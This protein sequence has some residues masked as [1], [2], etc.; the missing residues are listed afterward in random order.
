MTKVLFIGLVWPEPSSSAAGWRILHIV[1][2]LLQTHEVHFASAASKSSF[3]YDLKTIGVI[4]HQIELNNSS[5]DLFVSQLDPSMVVF[6]R[7]MIE[8]QYGWRIS[9]SVPHAVKILDTED[10]HF[11][12]IARQESVKK[13]IPVNYYN[14]TAKREIASILRCDLS[15]IISEFEMKLLKDRFKVEEDRLFFLPFQEDKL[16]EQQQRNDYNERANFVFIGNFIHE[17]N[18]RTVELL[19]TKIW[20]DL[21][22]KLPVAELHIYGAYASE[23]VNQLHNPKERFFIKGRADDARETLEKYRVLLAPIPF[24]AGA[25]GKFVDAM[26]SGT[27]SIT[28]V[29]GAENMS[30]DN[31]W[32]GYIEDDFVQFIEKAINLYTDRE[33]WQVLQGI[34]FDIFNSTIADNSYSEALLK[35]IEYALLNIMTIREKNFIGQ[36]L[37]QQQLNATKYM[38]LWIEQKNKNTNID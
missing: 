20:P 31:Q 1:K 3:S 7:F 19:K 14:E 12:R 29:V 6:D 4:E 17:P 28:T 8:E 2:L 26:Y 13:G 23:K 36:I 16:E 37:Q 38:S 27:P 18:W 11:L 33:E 24:G 5:F 25:K 32:G 15:L 9:E 10:L 30:V 21:R 34:G 22:R 35:W